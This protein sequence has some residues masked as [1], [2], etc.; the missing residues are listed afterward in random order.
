MAKKKKAQSPVEKAYNRE[1]NRIK[2]FIRE[3]EKRGYRFSDFS[4]PDKPK[5][6]TF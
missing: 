5:K 3:A 1:R 4:I 6:I 2:R